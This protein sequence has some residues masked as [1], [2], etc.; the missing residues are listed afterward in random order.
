MKR[1]V[2]SSSCWALSTLSRH[3]IAQILGGL[4]RARRDKKNEIVITAGELLRDEV[5]DT[6]FDIGERGAETKVR[7]AISWLERAG[8]VERNENRTSVFQA[9]PLVGHLDEA[10]QMLA[11][12]PLSKGMKALW[13]AILAHIMTAKIDEGLSADDLAELPECRAW[14][15]EHE[16]KE[17]S[18]AKDGRPGLVGE[19]P[20]AY[21]GPK[22]QLEAC[23]SSAWIIRILRDMANAGL[24][25]EDMQLTAFVRYQVA[26][27][28]RMRLGNVVAL[29]LAM[30]KHMQQEEPDPEGWLPLS[31]RRLNQRLMDDGHAST[32]ESLRSLLQSLSQDGRGLANHTGSIDLRYVSKDLYRIRVAAPMGSVVGH[33]GPAQ[34]PGERDPGGALCLDP[35][36]HA[37]RKGYTGQLLAG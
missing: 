2:K 32:P 5:V 34:A 13:L 4:R 21:G 10:E 23:T 27:D 9:R 31:L 8:Y 3:D 28:S 25:K 22:A 37:S 29:D 30:L 1:I 18:E 15:E 26:H 7:T 11:N 17:G 19:D 20:V 6:S 33:S 12:K 16:T 24:L 36:G 14:F 35:Q